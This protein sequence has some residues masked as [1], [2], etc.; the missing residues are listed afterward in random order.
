[1]TARIV[2]G[3]PMKGTVDGGGLTVVVVAITSAGGMMSAK[4][5]HS[6]LVAFTTV[7]TILSG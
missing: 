4:G 5:T 1:M 6:V 2:S 3:T 7:A